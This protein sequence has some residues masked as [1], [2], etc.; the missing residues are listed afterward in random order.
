LLVTEDGLTIALADNCETRLTGTVVDQT[1]VSRKSAGQIFSF[2]FPAHWPNATMYYTIDPDVPNQSR[3]LAAID[4]W[5]TR[6]PFSIMTRTTQPNYVRFQRASSGNACSSYV[7]MQGGAQAILL[8]ERGGP[9]RLLRVRY[10]LGPSRLSKLLLRGYF[11]IAVV[12]LFRVITGGVLIAMSTSGFKSTSS[13]ASAGNSAWLLLVDRKRMV[14]FRPCS[15]PSLFIASM[16]AADALVVPTAPLKMP[17]VT[18]LRLD[19]CPRAAADHVAAVPPI[20]KAINL[21]RRM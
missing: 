5:N 21:R 12:A 9:K 8:E 7:G 19:G 1:G 16:N 14:R 10:T 18:I 3:I 15:Y 17:T 20:I 13:A 2:L 4:H 11:G 6:T